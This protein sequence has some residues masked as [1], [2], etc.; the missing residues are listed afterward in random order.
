MD[1][2]QW[3]K[4]PVLQGKVNTLIYQVYDY[5]PGFKASNDSNNK[6]LALLDKAI[7]YYKL[8]LFCPFSIFVSCLNFL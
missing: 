3:I 4:K 1:P 5:Y 8:S 2:S 7:L 6:R